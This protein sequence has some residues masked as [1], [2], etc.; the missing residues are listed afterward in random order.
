MVEWEVRW[1]PDA[2]TGLETVAEPDLRDRILEAVRTLSHFPLAG[3]QVRSRRFG[4]VRRTVVA[5]F[6]LLYLPIPAAQLV[7]ILALIDGRRDWRAPQ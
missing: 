5:P 4:T 1:D 7:V 6:V 3:G 2:V